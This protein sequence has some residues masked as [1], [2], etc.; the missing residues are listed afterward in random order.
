MIQNILGS[1]IESVG[2][3]ILGSDDERDIGDYIVSSTDPN[4]V[5]NLM[6]LT[7]LR[8][9][10]AL[11]QK[12]RILITN[13][14]GPMHLAAALNILTV[15][16]FGPTDPRKTGPYGKNHK[17]F[18]TQVSCAPCF[19]RKCPLK[20]QLC[21]F[22]VITPCDVSHYIVNHIARQRPRKKKH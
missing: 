9:V 16:F 10:V 19:Q 6:G 18:Q 20:K 5:K 4:N 7:D 3:W 14:S 22:D 17:V 15:S 12:S 21:L 8:I 1:S 13:D 2:F 11:L